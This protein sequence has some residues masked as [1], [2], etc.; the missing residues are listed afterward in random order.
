MHQCNIEENNI[1]YHSIMINNIHYLMTLSI[2]FQILHHSA[3]II[4]VLQ[5]FVHE[6]VDYVFLNTR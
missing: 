2:N 3:V 5:L 1:H 4:T 6:H